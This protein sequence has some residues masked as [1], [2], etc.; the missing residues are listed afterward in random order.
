M[1][2]YVGNTFVIL[3]VFKELNIIEKIAEQEH[4]CIMAPDRIATLRS[5]NKVYELATACLPWQQ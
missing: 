3:K 2:A 1:M 4:E 5:D